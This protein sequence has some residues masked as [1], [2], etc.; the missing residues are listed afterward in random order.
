MQLEALSGSADSSTPG[1]DEQHAP[2]RLRSILG[3]DEG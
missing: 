3:E 1:G 2:K